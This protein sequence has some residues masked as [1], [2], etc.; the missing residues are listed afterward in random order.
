MF[1]APF[2]LR[3][4]EIFSTLN[5]TR[6]FRE[7][8]EELGIT[9]AS[10]SSQIKALETQMGIAF[11]NRSPGRRPTLLPA[12]EAFL[13]DL[14]SFE[15]VL[16]A[17]ASHRRDATPNPSSA[18]FRVLVGQGMFDCYIRKKLDHFYAENPTVELDFDTRL[19]FGALAQEIRKAGCDFALINQ[20]CDRDVLP[21]LVEVARVRGGIFGHRDFAK[22]AKLPL[23]ISEINNL[24]FILPNANSQ[25]EKEVMANYHSHGIK[26]KLIAGYSQYYDVIASMLEKGHGISSFSDALMKEESREFV[27]QLYPTQDWRLLWYRNKACADDTCDRVEA[28]L[29]GSIIDD[30]AYPRIDIA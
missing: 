30:P 8:A 20:R 10:V 22:G 15:E 17:L 13:A 27:I 9:Q 1:G 18:R 19:P 14:V 28:F 3:Q 2:T 21:E 11:F 29:I 16:R 7:T 25:Q 26:P 4:L 23:P 12:G 5:R 24:P 6:S